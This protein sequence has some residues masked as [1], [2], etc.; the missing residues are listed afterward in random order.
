MSAGLPDAAALLDDLITM[1]GRDDPTL[2]AMIPEDQLPRWRTMRWLMA[3]D[4]RRSGRTT[5]MALVAIAEADRTLN[6]PI[7]LWDHE[8]DTP[9]RNSVMQEMLRYFLEQLKGT[10]PSWR[11]KRFEIQNRSDEL[12]LVRVA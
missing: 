3:P 5:M 6:Y 9:R 10:Y 4:A 8:G 11:Q 12:F 2:K 7:R 1:P